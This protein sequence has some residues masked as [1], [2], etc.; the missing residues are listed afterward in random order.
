M[1]FKELEQ[2]DYIK[3]KE[4]TEKVAAFFAVCISYT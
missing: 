4:I 1:L 3:A 2:N